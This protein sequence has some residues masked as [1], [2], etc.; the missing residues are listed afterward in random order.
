MKMTTA[1]DIFRNPLTESETLDLEKL[2]SL[3]PVQ[4]TNFAFPTTPVLVGNRL[5]NLKFQTSWY[6]GRPW[7]EYSVQNDKACCF[8]C[9]LFKPTVNGKSTEVHNQTTTLALYS[10]LS[11]CFTDVLSDLYKKCY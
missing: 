4:P 6:Q 3:G 9:R 1:L 8:Y 2:L 11:H 7:L 10:V 5:K